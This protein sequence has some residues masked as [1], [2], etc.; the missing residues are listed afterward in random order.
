MSGLLFRSVR[1]RD[2]AAEL[3]WWSSCPSA[4][5]GL[6]A[7]GTE[8]GILSIYALSVEDGSGPMLVAKV[9]R[10]TGGIHSLAFLADGRLVVAG[11]DGMPWIAG[12][13][14]YTLEDGRTTWGVSEELAGWEDPVVAVRV[15]DR[16]DIWI[17]S[18]KEGIAR[19]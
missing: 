15:N 16:G 19:Y 17:A 3:S 2:E 4:Q 10:S 7:V 18:A 1:P 9:E 14:L 6:L 8:R 5:D 11:Q 13:D 12:R